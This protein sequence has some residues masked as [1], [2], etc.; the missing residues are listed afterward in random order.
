MSEFE[1]VLRG[2]V[3]DGLKTLDQARR[4]GHDYEVHLHGARIRDLLD[5]AARHGIDTGEWVDP[6]VLESATLGD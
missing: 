3:A 2:Q 6:A 5:M 1:A 4:A